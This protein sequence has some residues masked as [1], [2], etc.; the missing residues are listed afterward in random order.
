MW[1]YINRTL[2]IKNYVTT[3]SR[4]P[5][6]PSSHEHPESVVFA[7]SFARNPLFAAPLLRQQDRIFYSDKDQICINNMENYGVLLGQ[8]K[9]L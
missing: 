4:I 5:F 9:W 3:Q 2:L 7:F 8:A 1:S 6:A